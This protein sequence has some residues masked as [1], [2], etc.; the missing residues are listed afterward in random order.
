MDMAVNAQ[1]AIVDWLSVQGPGM[2]ALLQSIVNID[3]PSADNAGVEQVAQVLADFLIQ[4]GLDVRRLPTH[5]GAA[6]LDARLADTQ[7]RPV[8]LLLGHMDTVFPRGTVSRRPYKAQGDRLYGPGVA[9]M[10]AGLVMNAYVMAA[11][12]Q[13]GAGVHPMRALFTTDEEIASPASRRFI[14]QAALDASIALN[15][16]PGRANGNI[17]IARKG[18]LFVRLKIHGKATHS[19]IDFAGG[20]SAISELAHKIIALEQLT[21][22]EVGIT[23]NVGLVSGGLSI[24]TVAPDASASIDIRYARP[25]QRGDL[26]ARIKEIVH[27]TRTPGT[28]CELEIIGEFHPMTPSPSSLALLE[29]YRASARTLGFSVEGESTGGCSDAGFAASLGTPTLCG[30]GPVG[31]HAHTDDEYVE[32]QSLVPRAQALALTL[33]HHT[34]EPVTEAGNNRKVVTDR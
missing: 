26:L 19:G 27:S 7:S 8:P 29:T 5:S 4:Q 31:G 11:F 22:I 20:A 28:R 14:M 9:D 6:M 24:N 30:L 32:R 17:V 1:S 15:A 2:E 25:E 10:K 13:C 23:V 18:G 33:L 12:A 3:S 34:E 21:D 16:E